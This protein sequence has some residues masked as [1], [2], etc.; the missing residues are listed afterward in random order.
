MPT[1]GVYP[2]CDAALEDRDAREIEVTTIHLQELELRDRD[3]N[4]REVYSWRE[5]TGPDGTRREAY[6]LT[7]T[8]TSPA[9]KPT[10]E[11]G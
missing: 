2:S 3:R 8:D 11:G 1:V 5:I 4:V 7:S 10:A 9:G 6:V